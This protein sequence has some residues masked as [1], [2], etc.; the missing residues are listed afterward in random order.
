MCAALTTNEWCVIQ[1]K[2]S[3]SLLSVELS[4][5]AIVE[6]RNLPKLA[7]CLQANTYI[8]W[9]VK[10]V[11]VVY[12]ISR[13]MTTS[14][15]NTVFWGVTPCDSCKNRRSGGTISSVIRVTRICEQGTTLAVT[16]NRS[17][18]R[19]R[20]QILPDYQFVWVEYDGIN[21]HYPRGLGLQFSICHRH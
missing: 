2:T 8:L 11:D 14:F 20:N 7:S 21:D 17:T 15:K 10:I 19:A 12:K 3:H 6:K 18:A 16:S 9:T 4:T 1:N 5:E 13:D